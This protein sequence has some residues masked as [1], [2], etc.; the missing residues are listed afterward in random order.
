[1]IGRRSV[2]AQAIST[3][4]AT[5]VSLVQAQS[6]APALRRVGV[7]AP[8]TRAKEE[9]TLKPFFDEMRQLGW[10]EGQNI[11]YDRVYADDQQQTLSSLATDLVARKPEVIYAPPT[12]AAVVAK[13][14]TQ[15]I[16]IVFGF[17]ANPVGIGLV[18]SLARPGGNV[19]G[20]T[21]FS[22]SLAPKR[23]ELLREILPGVKRLGFLHDA[24]DSATTLVQQALAPL[25]TSWGLTTSFAGASNP[26]EFDAAVGR[27]VADRVD[28]IFPE[29][30]ASIIFNLRGRLFELANQKRLPV[31]GPSAPWAD[32]GALFSCGSSH[33]GRL[34]RQAQLVDKILKGTKPADIPV[35]QS[36][37]FELVVN[38][39]T[40]KALGIK[41][42]QSILLRADRVIE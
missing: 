9:V 1:M 30:S 6:S 34:R 35:E 19:T 26:V 10:A 15:T 42:P 17:V 36:T 8:S 37:V 18:V 40:A 20:V 11:T 33:A 13:M 2:I 16:P 22:E 25:V 23:I 38:L 5:Q 3:A 29:G 28:A 12:P 39:K 27:L 31:I 14:A 41:I 21:G 7:L 4:V 32:A 24:T